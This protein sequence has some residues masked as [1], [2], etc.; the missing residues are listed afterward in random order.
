MQQRISQLVSW[1]QFL[2]KNQ[3]LANIVDT[4]KA[5]TSFQSA[6]N[7]LRKAKREKEN[8]EKDLNRL[9]DEEWFGKDG[10]WK[11]LDKFCVEKD[12]GEYV[13]NL[14]FWMRADIF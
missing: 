7:D 4:S 5:R 2:F 3:V 10:A 6:E 8:A 11:K 12:T 1:I 9:Y 14:I 13:W